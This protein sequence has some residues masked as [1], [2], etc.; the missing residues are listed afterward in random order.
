MRSFFFAD[1]FHGRFTKAFIFARF[2]KRDFFMK[3]AND[4]KDFVSAHVRAISRELKDQESDCMHQSAN[5]IMVAPEKETCHQTAMLEAYK[6]V[7]DFIEDKKDKKY[8]Y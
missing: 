2:S 3:N 1:F 7:L 6:K 8:F 5:D 4:I